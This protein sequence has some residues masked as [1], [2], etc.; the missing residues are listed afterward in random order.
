MYFLGHAGMSYI[1][2]SCLSLCRNAFFIRL[3]VVGFEL[4]LDSSWIWDIRKLV[5]KLHIV[6]GLV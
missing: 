3:A 1:L 5:I 4:W 2:L 6:L